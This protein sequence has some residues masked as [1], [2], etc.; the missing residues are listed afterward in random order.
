[1]V[2][3]MG[4]LGRVVRGS[5]RVEWVVVAFGKVVGR[6]SVSLVV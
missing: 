6:H 2:M 4:Q 1:M 5:Y 3:G